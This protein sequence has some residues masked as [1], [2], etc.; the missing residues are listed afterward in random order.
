MS[1]RRADGSS[2]PASTVGANKPI[3]VRSWFDCGKFKK[4]AETK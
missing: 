2:P 1:V 4:G 3:V